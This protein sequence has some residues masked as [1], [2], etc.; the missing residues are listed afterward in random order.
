MIVNGS[1]IWQKHA[2]GVGNLRDYLEVLLDVEIQ[3]QTQM[4]SRKRGYER[5]PDICVVKMCYGYAGEL[6]M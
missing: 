6:N 4:L 1:S 2:G 3:K 5:E